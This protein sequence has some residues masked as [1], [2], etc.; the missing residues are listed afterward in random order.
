MVIESERTSLTLP[1]SSSSALE[2]DAGNVS[3]V[4]SDSITI[5][6]TPPPAPTIPRANLTGI[7]ATCAYIEAERSD[8]ADFWQ[9]E[10][11]SA[12]SNWSE[13]GDRQDPNDLFDP[14]DEADTAHIK[15]ALEQDNDNLLQVRVRD[16][17]GNV[18]E[19]STALVE[20]VSSYLIPSD[21]RM[22]Q[23]CNGGQYAILK[24]ELETDGAYARPTC[25]PG[26]LFIGDTPEVATSGVS[27]MNNWPGTQV[28][29]A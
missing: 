22:K 27:P 7:N 17:A 26:Q 3:E 20:E 19:A 24:E 23:V 11:R 29:R 12:G 6:L 14:S 10:F 9:F 21:L 5:D 25:V 8:V 4:L 16:K 18:S 2:D 15:F 13:M 28:G 1:A